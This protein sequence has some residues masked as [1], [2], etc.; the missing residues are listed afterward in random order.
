MGVSR[1]MGAPPPRKYCRTVGTIPWYWYTV[2][3]NWSFMMGG[4]LW[5]HLKAFLGIV[6][7]FF[8]QWY[9]VG[10]HPLDVSCD[11]IPICLQDI[12]CLWGLVIKWCFS[13][14]KVTRC[15]TCQSCPGG[16]GVGL[17][18][19]GVWVQILFMWGCTAIPSDKVWSPRSRFFIFIYYMYSI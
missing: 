16:Y 10:H 2:L 14:N 11:S 17:P 18:C 13:S 12:P 6:C 8:L 15:D 3:K 9:L 5:S 7:F 19:R 4:G 1:L